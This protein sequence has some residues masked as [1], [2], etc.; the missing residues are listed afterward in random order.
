[1]I[2]PKRHEVVY[3]IPPQIPFVFPFGAFMH[4]MFRFLP[5]DNTE[6]ST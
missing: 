5:I 2:T 3:L 6:N 1:M 4:I